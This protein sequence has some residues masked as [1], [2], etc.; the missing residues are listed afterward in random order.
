MPTVVKL[1]MHGDVLAHMFAHMLAMCVNTRHVH[2]DILAHV[3]TYMPTYMFIHMLTYM[4]TYMFTHMLTY[5][6]THVR[7]RT[8]F[9]LVFTQTRV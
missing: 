5:M 7:T 6:P 1:P 8:V 2:A 3:L 4:P 9:A